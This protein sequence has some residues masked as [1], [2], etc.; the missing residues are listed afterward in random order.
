MRKL[1]PAFCLIVLLLFSCT[2][3]DLKPNIVGTVSG[4]AY[5]NENQEPYPNLT[6]TV[7]EYRNTQSFLRQNSEE[8]GIIGSGVT[9]ANGKYS[10][11]YTTSGNGNTYYLALGKLARNIYLIGPQNS[12]YAFNVNQYR[13][14][15]QITNVG[16]ALTYDFNV[17]RQYYMKSR[18]TVS[19]NLNPPLIPIFQSDR[20]K[21][22]GGVQVFGK[23]NDTTVYIPIV[24]N[25]GGFNIYFY[26]TNHK[27][28]S[29]YYSKIM[30]LNPLIN[31]DT[32]DGPVYTLDVATFK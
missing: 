27:I 9:D 8:I 5:D 7:T 30:P 2:K 31:K 11:K 4:V 16:G 12:L 22:G 14:I 25:T 21:I 6:V 28:D 3:K 20:N 15:Q 32:I 1:T 23:S 24:K 19:N 18:I 29:S 17:T 26:V 13:K 10:F